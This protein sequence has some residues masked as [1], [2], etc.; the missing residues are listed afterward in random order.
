MVSACNTHN[1]DTAKLGNEVWLLIN[2]VKHRS[3][4]D[5]TF[6]LNL[7]SSVV[8]VWAE[9][10]SMGKISNWRALWMFGKKS[11]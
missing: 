9:K 3:M 6:E 8:Y 4:K 10:G 5:T 11:N 2:D 1:Q 7:E